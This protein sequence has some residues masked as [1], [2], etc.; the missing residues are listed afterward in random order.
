MENMMTAR[1]Y[2]MKPRFGQLLFS[3]LREAALTW[4]KGMV[5]NLTNIFYLFVWRRMKHNNHRAQE[6]D[7]TAQLSERT[8]LFF[9]KVGTKHRTTRTQRYN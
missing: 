6:A 5:E 8:K 2:A 1:Q 7:C 3:R 4:P 9:Q